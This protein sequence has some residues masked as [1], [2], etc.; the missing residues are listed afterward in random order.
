MKELKRL[1]GFWKIILSIVVVYLALGGL[2]F[3]YYQSGDDS[4]A[5][6]GQ[7]GDMF[8]GITAL[9]GSLTFAGVLYTI[10]LQRK[11]LVLTRKELKS[12]RIAFEEQNITTKIQRF[13]N[14]F[15]KMIDAFENTKQNLEIGNSARVNYR[16]QDAISEL[17]IRT[18][19]KLARYPFT[20]SNLEF[21]IHEYFKCYHLEPKAKPYFSRITNILELIDKNKSSM[22]E[23]K[24]YIKILNTSIA[25]DSENALLYYHFSL[26]NE[27]SEEVRRFIVDSDFFNILNTSVFADSTHI[28]LINYPKNLSVTE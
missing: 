7:F 28:G 11:E 13:E 3:W 5:A 15:F 23:K 6:A 8:G 4:N 27:V 16:G 2:M 24:F 9:F 20:G 21:L 1:K 12:S 22:E 18:N 25:S 10:I 14:T 17:L 19:D 26:Y